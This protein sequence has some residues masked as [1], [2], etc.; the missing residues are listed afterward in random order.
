MAFNAF[1]LPVKRDPQT[2][3]VTA[4]DFPMISCEIDRTIAKYPQHGFL[5]DYSCFKKLIFDG[6]WMFLDAPRIMFETKE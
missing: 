4:T 6:P 5:R 3:A 1:Q 2:P